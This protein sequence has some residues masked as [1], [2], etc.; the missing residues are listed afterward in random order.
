MVDSQW[1]Q[2]RKGRDF[3]R[4]P[5]PSM[6]QLILLILLTRRLTRRPSGLSGCE[7]PIHRSL[8]DERHEANY[9]LLE[10]GWDLRAFVPVGFHW[11]DVAP[12]IPRRDDVHCR[13]RDEFLVVPLSYDFGA[14]GILLKVNSP[15]EISR[16]CIIIYLFII[17]SSG[18][19]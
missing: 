1:T 11:V 13:G 12:A 5:S 4:Y 14:S 18:P 19:F 16:T 9:W 2:T 8:V 15:I 6:V 7:A 10:E 17:N 3:S